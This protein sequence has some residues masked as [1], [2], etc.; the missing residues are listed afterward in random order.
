MSNTPANLPPQSIEAEMAVLGS[1]MI[2]KDAVEKA[3]DALEERD[4]Y[5]DAHRKIFRSARDLFTRG[6]G[7]DLVTIGE[8][9]R[10]NKLLE[11][12]GGQIYLAELI[13]KVATAAHVDYYAKIVREKAILREMITAATGIVTSCYGEVKE[14]PALLDEAQASIMRVAERQGSH[15]VTEA[16]D[17]AHEVIEIIELRAKEKKAVTGVPSGLR[18]LDQATAGFQKSDLIL[19]AARPSQGKTALALSIAAN[20]VLDTKEPRAVLLFSMEMAKQA[21]ME[22]FIASEARVDLSQIRNGYF[23]REKWTALT[24]A[25]ATFSEAPLFINDQPGL[26][27]LTVRSV[28]RQLAADLRRKGKRLDM[29][30]VDYLQLMRGSGKMESRQQ[31]VS[32]ISRGL[33]F[34]ARDLNLPVIALSQLSRRTEEKGRTDGRPQLSDLR[35]SGALEQ[36]ADLVAFIY[37]EAF[38]KPNDPNVDD[39]KAEIIIAKQRQGPTGTVDVRFIRKYT[40]FE[41]PAPEGGSSEPSP[42]DVEPIQTTSF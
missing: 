35:E 10:R 29:I 20:A 27:V 24:N 2:E 23:P 7:V 21:I 12:V 4:F 22:R 18:Y 26:S 32:E 36:D 17:L 39:S 40:R 25:A 9:L 42:D 5:Q 34:L 31:E 15:S 11:D 37:R 33:K 41:N 3:V 30:V 28:S 8:D 38:Y 1:M 6:D 13:H 19:I 16:K 14:A